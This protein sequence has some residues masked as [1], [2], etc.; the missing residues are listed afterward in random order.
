MQ[1]Y[2]E[3]LLVFYYLI[4]FSLLGGE[5]I[6]TVQIPL[7]N[8]I[9]SSGFQQSILNPNRL[10]MSQSFSIST[11]MAKGFSQTSGVYSNFAT[12]QISEKLKFN[13]G[14]HFIQS[15]SQLPFAPQNQS[16]IAYEFGLE[17]QLSNNSI[18]SFQLLNFNPASPA[19]LRD[20]LP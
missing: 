18:F 4:L 5:T 6:E 7:E 17:Y 19:L 9:N 13:T 15:R 12:Y 1:K 14:L 11:T 16:G 2:P 10:N 3:S 8:N 20:P